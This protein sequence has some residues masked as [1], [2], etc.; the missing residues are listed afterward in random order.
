[1]VSGG[2]RGAGAADAAAGVGAAGG[3]PHV[4][5]PLKVGPLTI[6][7]R[8]EVSPA[9]NHMASKDGWVTREF[10]AFTGTLASSGAGIV[11]IGDSPVTQTYFDTCPY[12]I[13]LS[14]PLVVNGLVWA[15]EAIHRHD[16]VASIE[17]NLR[18]EERLPA[19]YTEAELHAIVD[20]FA[21]AARH[22]RQ[23][24]FDM[25]MVH[26][27][28]GHVIDQFFSPFFNKRTDRYGCNSLDDRCRFAREVVAA[29]RE[30][31]GRNMALELRMS[32]DERLDAER[33][34]P[35]GEMTE[36]AVRMQDAV[37]LLHVS[38]GNLYDM[39]AGD[40]MIQGAYMPR[41]TNR[42]LAAHIKRRV[43]V[44]VT[45]VGS[46]T[47]PLA[48]EALAAGDCDVVAMIRSFIA[49]PECAVKAREGRADEI[50]P[51]L[52]CNSCTGGGPGI[53]PKPTRCAVNPL[54]GRE[55]DFPAVEPAARPKHVAVV[56]GGAG[57]M[58][59]ARWLAR[60]GHRPVIFERGDA[61]GGNL[62]A[63]GE[64]SLKADVRAYADWSR[65]AV[66][67]DPRIAVR[68]GVEATPALLAGEGFN[69]AVIALGAA[70]VTPDVPGVD[71]PNVVQ[72]V[73]V[74]ADPSLAGERVVVVGAGLTGAET[75]L[76]LARR[77]RDVTVV[78]RRTREALLAEQGM[79]LFKAYMYCDDAGVR[80]VEGAT[81]AACT[82]EGAVVRRADGVEELLA[83]DTVVLSLGLRPA[84][85]EVD[86]LRAAVPET[87]VIGD[88]KRPRLIN[89]AVREA[90]FAAMRI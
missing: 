9:E 62:A 55:L 23:A 15:V 7:N 11:T 18:D 35:L 59:A 5:R 10:A 61:L 19:D 27:G 82:P 43:S 1:M 8:L 41:A 16:A 67:A 88:C 46:Y 25:V 84:V 81:L 34:V 31:I 14:D 72:A 40:Y 4:F 48:E 58:E 78:V 39:R 17:L 64:N 52:R 20:A 80:F 51:C 75:A 2:W 76:D 74:D 63:A 33:N 87:Y 68:L 32:G 45:S 86:A 28:H 53:K 42:A 73:A 22:A 85:A 60:R 57:G 56:G 54:I 69:A 38:A 44:P 3:F 12:T 47:M 66:A 24:G 65:R 70:P 30:E 79:N 90:F 89:D 49:D 37:D 26:A 71:L 36:F 83:C 77:G 29:V 50:R 21:T 13:N 6:K